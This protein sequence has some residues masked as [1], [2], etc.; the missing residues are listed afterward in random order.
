VQPTIIAH[1]V[2]CCL[3]LSLY[4]SAGSAVVQELGADVISAADFLQLLGDRFSAKGLTDGGNHNALL[5]TAAPQD[6]LATA[7]LKVAS[8]TQVRSNTG[9]DMCCCCCAC[10]SYTSGCCGIC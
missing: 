7:V 10:V 2:R 1:M 5:V 8:G 9:Q 4:H 6:S 3:V